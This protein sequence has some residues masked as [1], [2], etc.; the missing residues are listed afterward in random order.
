MHKLFFC[1]TLLFLYAC[2]HPTFKSKWTKE[3]A[4][5][6]FT[7]RFETSKGNFDVA[8]TRSLSPL[9]ADRFYQLV[10]HHYFDKVLF[11]R[12]VP[13]FVAQFGNIDTA[14]TK[15][16]EQ[17]IIKDEPVTAGNLKGTISFARSVADS[18]GA[19][20]FINLNDNKRL[21]TV[22]YFGV[23]GFPVFGK[24]TNGMNVVESLYSGYANA[25][26]DVSDSLGK[27]KVKFL[28]MFPKLD[29]IKR[30]YL[31]KQ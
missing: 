22:S 29:S 24:V 4:P 26:M 28:E 14:A 16:W 21:D 7:A 1:L 8:I 30:A 13:G 27:D 18:R 9:A 2:S 3:K 19:H 6:S 11:Y 10:R 15:K 17:H 23:T 25:T 12:V 31:L 20:L 5:A